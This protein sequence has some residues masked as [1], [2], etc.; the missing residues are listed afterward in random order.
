MKRWSGREIA[1]RGMLAVIGGYGLVALWCA[2][3][4]RLLPITPLDATLSA[5]MLA[6][7]LYALLA[8]WV[9]AA[10]S[11]GRVCGFGALAAL[12]GLALLKG[13]SL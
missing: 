10:R 11:V 2:A 12:V 9:F 6:F 13:A 7:P 3:I 8:V 5:T 1:I 4:A